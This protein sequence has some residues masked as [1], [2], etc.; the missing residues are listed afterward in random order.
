MGM[1]QCR[2]RLF[3]VFDGG[4]SSNCPRDGR[5]ASFALRVASAAAVVVVVAALHMTTTTMCTTTTTQISANLRAVLL[6]N[7]KED[8]KMRRPA[9]RDAE[10]PTSLAPAPATVFSR[11]IASVGLCFA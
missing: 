9:K 8:V 4:G 6:V 2:T 11:A 5:G 1:Y 7:T 10:P 3:V